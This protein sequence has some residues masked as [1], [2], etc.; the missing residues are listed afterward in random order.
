MFA[1][2]PLSQLIGGLIWN[3]LMFVAGAYLLWIWPLQVRR[4]VQSGKLTE[5]EAK[6]KLR[7]T[8]PRLGYL[9]FLVAL[10]GTILGLM[11]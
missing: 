1:S 9:A 5:T 3:G 8:N 7:K 11:R 6:E 4:Q 2:I 10:G